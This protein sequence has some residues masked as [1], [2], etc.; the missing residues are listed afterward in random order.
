MRPIADARAA[1][2]EDA[3]PPYSTELSG[4]ESGTRGA[5]IEE[6]RWSRPV[7]ARTPRV[8]RVAEG[9]AA[10]SGG[11]RGEGV[12]EGSGVGVCVQRGGVLDVLGGDDVVAVEGGD[13]LVVGGAIAAA[14]A[15]A[16]GPQSGR[17]GSR[18][19]GAGVGFGG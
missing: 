7:I 1:A 16:G 13:P 17:A 9:G 6:G 5:E 19:G 12:G 11:G 8:P 3:S 2:A 15:A 14:V 10:E 18:G 4:G